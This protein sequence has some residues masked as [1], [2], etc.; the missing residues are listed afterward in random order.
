MSNKAKFAQGISQLLGNEISEK[1]PVNGLPDLFEPED[2]L[3]EIHKKESPEV[4]RLGDKEQMARVTPTGDENVKE[5]LPAQLQGREAVRANTKVGRS[6]YFFHP[7]SIFDRPGFNVR[8]DLGDIEGLAKSILE[9]KQ[10]QPIT[11]D[12]VEEN[13]VFKAYIADGY[14]RM[15]AIR[16]LMK[17]G[18]PVEQVEAFVNNTKTSEV[19]RISF[20]FVSQD[21][22]QLESVEVAAC[23]KRLR[24]IGWT[25]VAIAA[26]FG[27]SESYVRDMLLLANE[28]PEVQDMVLQKKVSTTA[29]IELSRKVKDPVRRREIIRNEVKKG[30]GFT[31]THVDQ[32]QPNT[33]AFAYKQLES[34]K[35]DKDILFGPEIG[36]FA[37]IMISYQEGNL[38]EQDLREEIRKISDIPNS[39]IFIFNRIEDFKAR[40]L[41]YFGEAFQKNMSI[42]IGYLTGSVPEEELMDMKEISRE[43]SFDKKE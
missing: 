2:K 14:R 5:L 27:K 1:A 15:A 24:N 22:K 4:V 34:I 3:V 19:D 18:H 12:Y 28:S 13:G 20:M 29:V 38:S 31:T 11:V 26:K 16:F 33:A 30:K 7:D 37:D 35:K 42:F 9:N 39:P 23:F 43:E 10:K 41:P 21:N 32:L 36:V 8:Q 17:S 6:T 40:L 25:Q